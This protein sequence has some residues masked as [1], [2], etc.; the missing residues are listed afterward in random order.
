MKQVT[1]IG[2]GASGMAAAIAAARAGACVTILE[3][4]EQPGKKLM[5][6]GNGRCNFT[7]AVMEPSCYY[8]NDPAFIERFLRSFG[9]EEALAFFESIGILY[10]ERNGYYYP[11]HMQAS[12]VTSALLSE[13]KKLNVQIITNCNVRKLKREENGNFMIMT[14]AG[15]FKADRVIL[16]CGSEAGVK[17][18]NAFSA[19]E[20]LKNAGHSVYEIRPALTCLTGSEGYESFWNGVR[21]N[22]CVSYGNRKENGEIQLTA[23]GISGIAVFQLSREVIREV[24]S[25]GRADV[26]LDLLPDHD[27]KELQS[28]I[29][30]AAFKPADSAETAEELLSGWIHKKLIRIVLKKASIDPKKLL[31]ALTDDEQ[32]D[33]VKALKSFEYRVTGYGDLL[34][35]QTVQGGVDTREITERFESIRIPGLYITGELLDVDGICG[36]YNLHFAWGSGL[37]A[38]KAA[39]ET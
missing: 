13:L 20:M 17:D 30:K 35:S 3:K 21:V 24:V 37:A 25:S 31:T 18:P 23:E 11:N 19:Y 2:A 38:G 4:K 12:G 8:G 32:E 36:G 29:R 27:I 39:A 1:V 9:T 28:R 6:T 15:E 34:K 22:G 5:L 16:A 7:N 33:L 14:S 26:T 10:S